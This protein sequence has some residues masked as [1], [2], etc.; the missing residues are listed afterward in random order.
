MD[1]ST[2]RNTPDATGSPVTDALATMSDAAL[3]SHLLDGVSRTFALTIPQLPPDLAGVVSN[4]YLLCRIIDTIEDEP[5]LDLEQKRH[6]SERFV[7]AVA[8]SGDPAGLAAELA[9]LLSG[10]TIPAEHELIRLTPRVLQITHGFSAGKRRILDRCVRIMSAGMV[11]FQAA[12]PLRGLD[13]LTHLDRYCYFVA[14]IVGETLTLLYCD[15]SPEIATRKD[16]LMRLGVSFGQ[17]L[18]MTN[19]L[20]DIWDDLD[21]GACWL[22]RTVFDAEGFDLD[23]LDTEH[24]DPAFGRG[25][26]ELVAVAREHLS[27]AL[28]YT[29]LI[30]SGEKGIRNFCLWALGMAVLTLRK[31]NRR[32]EFRS[33]A[34]VK[35]TRRSVKS[36]VAASR[37]T[38]GNNTMIRLLFEIA[39]TGLPSAPP[40]R[41]FDA[42]E[43]SGESAHR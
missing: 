1:L 38:A 14:G 36:T 40:P 13:D 37:V 2:S 10:S 4:A 20:K 27:N 15:Y 23:E 39:A 9:P 7:D 3:Q 16:E 31:I 22:P 19:I 43:V 34:E 21:R 28:R 17:G 29:Q 8:G 5:A 42:S 32:P 30:P 33:G 6:F 25:L 18:Q 35:I 12:R 41:V 24:Y 26:R 11:E